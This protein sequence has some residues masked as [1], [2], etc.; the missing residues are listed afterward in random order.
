MIDVA[1]TGRAQRPADVAVVI[2]VLRATSTVTQA[3]A[4]GYERVRCVSSVEEALLLR[5]PGRVL[6]GER[7]CL[8]PP[9]FDQGNS[10]V[11]ASVR[12]GGELVLATTNGAPAIVSAGRRSDEVM[13]ACLLNLGAVI[14]ALTALGEL[15]ELQLQ[16][17]CAGTDGAPAI[18]D[19]YVAGALCGALAGARTDAARIAES[20]TSCYP[21]PSAAVR[22][23]AGAAALYRSGLGGDIADCELVSQ[24]ALVPRVCAVDDQSAV[25]AGSGSHL[26]H[27]ADV[28]VAFHRSST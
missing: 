5:A 27:L 9:G 25:V 19:T 14:E 20:V 28:P 18:E 22:A 23:G 24:I 21:T 4:A 2:D 11:D 10:P 16:I 3:L 26:L 8:M 15:D 6:A 12:R 1:L 17:V 13:L 7:G